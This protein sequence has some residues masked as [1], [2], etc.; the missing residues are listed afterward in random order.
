M[1]I[2]RYNDASVA[3]SKAGK[4]SV[5]FVEK[6]TNVDASYYRETLQQRCLLPEIRQNSEVWRSFSYQQNAPPPMSHRVREV[7]RRVLAAYSAELHRTVCMSPP[8]QPGLEPGCR[9]TQN[10]KYK[11]SAPTNHSFSSGN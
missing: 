4:T 8:Q 5:H 2:L 11:R 10:F 3:V 1:L 9:L 7:D 6:G